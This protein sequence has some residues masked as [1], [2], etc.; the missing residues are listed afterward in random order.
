[1]SDQTKTTGTLDQDGGDAVVESPT[2]GTPDAEESRD[3]ESGEHSLDYWK[4]MALAYKDKV[5]R[6]NDQDRTAEPEGGQPQPPV[7]EDPEVQAKTDQIDDLLEKAAEFERRGDPV[8]ALSLRTDA[9]LAKL[10]R[11]TILREQLAEMPK[12]VRK[13]VIAHFNKHHR[14]L[15]DMNAALAEIEAPKLA[16]ENRALKERL[17]LLEKPRDPDVVNAPPTHG[18]EFGAR[19]TKSRQYTEEQFDAEQERIRATKGELAALKFADRL[20]KDVT[21][22]R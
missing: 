19:E 15:G 6:V 5:E 14:R 22:K 2:A 18:R 21:L 9:R 3:A 17:A 7:A 20:G 16:A 10:E 11:D 13:D 1:M 8:A 12:D 4:G